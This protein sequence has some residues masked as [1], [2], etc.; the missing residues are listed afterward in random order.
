MIFEKERTNKERAQL[1]K[2]LQADREKIEAI[3]SLSGVVG[4]SFI[5]ID[6]GDVVLKDNIG[7][8]NASTQRPVTSDTVFPIASLTKGFTGYCVDRLYTDGKLSPHDLINSRLPEQE[9]QPGPADALTILD[10]VAHRTGVWEPSNLWF[11]ADGEI[12]LTQDQVLP[13]FRHLTPQDS[14][15]SV[16]H[17]SNLGY[18]VLGDIIVKASGQPYH[19]FLQK[20]LLDPLKM[21]RTMATDRLKTDGNYSLAYT[22]WEDGSPNAVSSPGIEASGPLGAAGGYWS[23]AN[24]LAKFCKALMKSWLSIAQ[25]EHR[26]DDKKPAEGGLP[27]G[28]DIVQLFSPIQVLDYPVFREKSYAMGWA[29]SQLPSSVGDFGENRLLV[30]DM[31]IL[32]SGILQPHESRLAVWNQGSIVGATHFVMMLPETDSA[33]IV[34]TNTTARNDAADWIGQLLVETLLA[35]GSPL[36]RNDYVKLAKDSMKAAS[37][38]YLGIEKEIKKGQIS[39]GPKRPLGDYVG[40]YVGFGGAYC[41]EIADNGDGELKIL[42]QGLRTQSHGLAHH[43]DQTFCWFSNYEE[44][45]QRGRYFLYSVDPFF[46]TFTIMP[47]QGVNG[48]RWIPDPEGNRA[49]ELFKKVKAKEEEEEGGEVEA[50]EE[51]EEEEEGGGEVEM[52]EL[53]RTKSE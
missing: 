51:E 53:R 29:R 48:I 9:M 37:D 42:F 5:V 43:H 2:A 35:K 20:S 7:Y 39:G 52:S 41:I 50:S 23:T 31:P 32:G 19:E 27:P 40:R 21:T 13:M 15:R 25:G 45:V 26:M 38:R 12:M 30:E 28:S 49:G 36:P 22:V 11:G 34:L 10:L 44:H 6:N 4:L 14:L 17:Y 3:C 8:R 18:A 1:N 16:F 46:I 47:D 33:V 24:D